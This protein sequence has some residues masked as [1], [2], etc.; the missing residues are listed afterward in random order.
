L[1]GF[2]VKLAHAL[3]AYGG[4]GL[5]AASFL[6][7]TFVPLPTANDAFLM[8]LSSQKPHLAWV[9]ALQC[10]AGSLLG[11]YVLYGVA[12]G[13]KQLV[14]MSPEKLAKARR[15]L[16]R[17]EF[18]A[19]LVISLLPPPAPFKAFLLAAG[20]LQINLVWFGLG[21]LVGRGLRFGAEAWLGAVYGARAAAYFKANL[22]WVSLVLVVVI[23][24]FV[25]LRRAFKKPE[26]SV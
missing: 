23:V 10:T 19:M 4:W 26:A 13:G 9:Y 12:R 2:S 14:K 25:L 6:D 17:N 5:M 24:G 18:V 3:T 16:E 20:F 7:S 15:W 11:A 1:K 8:Y 21:L 22:P